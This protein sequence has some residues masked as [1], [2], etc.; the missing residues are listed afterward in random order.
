MCVTAATPVTWTK[1]D[2][3]EFD[4]E[5]DMLKLIGTVVNGKAQA[6]MFD[7]SVRTLKKLPSKE[8]LNALI[9]KSGGEVIGDDF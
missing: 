9:T 6:A 7:G 3:L 1:P 5:K 4:P 8:T 2:E